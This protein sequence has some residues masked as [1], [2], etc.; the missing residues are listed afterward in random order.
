MSHQSSA[1]AGIAI[2]VGHVPLPVDGHGRSSPEKVEAPFRDAVRGVA[3]E[4][5]GRRGTSL[6]GKR[7]RNTCV[8]PPGVTA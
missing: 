8:T 7:K 6:E 1:E 2:A 5:E 3:Q 4:L